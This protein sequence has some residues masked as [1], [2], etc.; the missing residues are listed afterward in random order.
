MKTLAATLLILVFVLGVTQMT[1]WRQ[2]VQDAAAQEL[3][4]MEAELATLRDR[5][6]GYWS[7]YERLEQELGETSDALAQAMAERDAERDANEPLRRQIEALSAARLVQATKETTLRNTLTQ[8]EERAAA[9][10]GALEQARAE[11]SSAAEQRAAAESQ[12]Q[13]TEESVQSLE[14]EVRRL[15][16]VE[17]EVRRLQGIEVEVQRLTGLEAELQ[18]LQR[19]LAEALRNAAEAK[20]AHE[21]LLERKQQAQA[22]EAGQAQPP[23]TADD[24][25]RP[26]EQP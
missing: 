13:S 8:A 7:N 24:A 26:Q 22:R 18:R 12:L 20:A 2:R 11:A 4:L 15:Q 19:Q 21:E 23:A 10:S 14:A 6:Q 5:F 17:A 1:R 25:E 16:G 9:L 3:E